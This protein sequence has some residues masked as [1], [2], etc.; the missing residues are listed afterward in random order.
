MTTG[1]DGTAC[2]DHLPFGTY[3]V[4]E[5]QAPAGYDIDNTSGVSVAVDHNADCTTGTPNA[6]AAFTG[7][8]VD[9]YR[10]LGDLGGTGRDPVDGHLH[11]Y[12]HRW[13]DNP[14]QQRRAEGIGQRVRH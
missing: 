2:V 6:P 10:G 4:T 1:G 11:R 9:R 7:H 13:Q 5:T 14:Q 12:F 8:A 3:T